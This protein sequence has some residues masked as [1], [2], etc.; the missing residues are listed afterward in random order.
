M[1]ATGDIDPAVVFHSAARRRH[2]RR[3]RCDTLFNKSRHEGRDR[4]VPAM[5]SRMGRDPQRWTGSSNAPASP[6]MR[7]H[8]LP[9]ST[10]IYRAERATRTSSPSPLASRRTTRSASQAGERASPPS[11]W[12]VGDAVNSAGRAS[13]P[14]RLDG[15]NRLPDQLGWRRQALTFA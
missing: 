14:P 7:L 15:D 10:W 1:G 9:L 3:R 5:R 6:W 8:W 11:A 4:R 2:E 12:I 13:F